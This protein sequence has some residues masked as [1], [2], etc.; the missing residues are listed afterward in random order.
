[1][2]QPYKHTKV[3][4]TK[5]Q[6]QIKALLSEYGIL[7]T[8]FTDLLSKG[9]IIFEFVRPT[10]VREIIES[11]EEQQPIPIGIR[12][13]VPEVDVKTINQ[14]YRALYWYLKSKFESLRFGFLEFVQEFMGSLLRLLPPPS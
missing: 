13:I 11:E 14:K 4:S 6:F 3:S 5:T 10:P 7:D 12:I 9:Q 2:K 1:M 8:R